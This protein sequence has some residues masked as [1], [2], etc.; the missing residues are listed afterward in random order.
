MPAEG[1]ELSPKDHILSDDEVVRLA[2]LFVQS[3]VKKIRL[4]GGEPTVRKGLANL[5]GQCSY[6]IVRPG[7]PDLRILL[8]AARLNQL[9]SHGLQSIG[10]TT[11]GIALHRRL[12]ELVQQGL[13]H[14]NIRLV[15]ALILVGVCLIDDSTS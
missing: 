9:R 6:C 14:L 13:T 12:P 8:Y 1:V 11:N 10:M 2:S 15:Y 3:G 7:I 4:T 5:M